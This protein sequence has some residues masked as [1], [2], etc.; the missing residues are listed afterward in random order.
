LLE[1]SFGGIPV[2]RK[3]KVDGTS[4]QDK[5]KYYET[6]RLIYKVVVLLLADDH[7]YFAARNPVFHDKKT[8]N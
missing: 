5:K 2:N 3:N 4:T 7:L 1:E 8:M 6:L